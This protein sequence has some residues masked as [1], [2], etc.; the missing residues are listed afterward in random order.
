MQGLLALPAKT[1]MTS[2]RDLDNG[3]L[4]NL[5][6]YVV[7]TVLSRVDQEELVFWALR[8]K[9]QRQ[10]G[11]E[12]TDNTARKL[13]RVHLDVQNIVDDGTLEGQRRWFP[14]SSSVT[15]PEAHAYARVSP[16]ARHSPKE[17]VL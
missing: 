6:Y 11:G 8:E 3:D 7:T 10:K 4:Q 5:A 17:P 9:T 12:R 14:D 1:Q 13:H 2:L 16:T 15:S